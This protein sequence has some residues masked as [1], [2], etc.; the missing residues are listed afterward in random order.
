MVLFH[1][2]VSVNESANGTILPVL[3]ILQC[4]SANVIEDGCVAY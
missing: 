2:D 1:L 3:T 4:N